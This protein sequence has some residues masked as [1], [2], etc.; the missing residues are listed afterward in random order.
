MSYLAEQNIIGILLTDPSNVRTIGSYVTPEMFSDALLGRVYLEIVRA[1]DNHQEVNIPKIVQ[2]IPRD[3]WPEDVVVKELAECGNVADPIGSTI[4]GYAEVVINDFK[5]KQFSEVLSCVE[6]QPAKV[7]DQIREIVTKL[8]GLLDNKK[9]K[10]RSLAEIAEACKGNYFVDRA[11]DEIFLGIPSLDDIIGG[12][13]GGDVIIIGARPAV[14][15]S[16]FSTQAALYMA[17]KGKKVG[18]YN[19]EMTEDQMYERYV[20]SLSGIGLT[21]VRR[22]KRFLGDEEL[23]YHE[24][25]EYLKT[26]HNLIIVS[27]SKTAGDIKSEVR[28]MGYDVIIIDYLQLILSDG[29]YRGN[30]YA[31]VGHISKMIKSIAMD[32]K[33]PVILLSQLNRL[34]ESREIKEPTMSELR[35][36]GDIEQDASVIILM[37]NKDQD[38]DSIK[39]CK[40]EKARQSRKGKI[41]LKF[42]GNLMKFEEVGKKD[43]GWMEVPADAELPF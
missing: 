34:S 8:E 27:G 25:N 24:A 10:A 16:A 20:S 9:S 17:S 26:L 36:S 41:D 31:E 28:N 1:D 35:E 23:K 38:N 39:G 29:A 33:I 19:L 21:R 11:D 14:G 13:C 32:L 43:E 22:A 5:A 40:V 6:I 2:S 18:Y 4:K 12:L 3:Q 7:D 37:W 15:K 30:R 42:N